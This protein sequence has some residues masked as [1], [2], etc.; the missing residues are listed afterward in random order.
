M[1]ACAIKSMFTC[2]IYQLP[3]LLPQK[4]DNALSY[5][6]IIAANL[7]VTQR[8]FVLSSFHTM[9]GRAIN[10]DSNDTCFIVAVKIYVVI[11]TF[12]Y[13]L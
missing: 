1:L 3:Q 7:M 9:G 5:T 4:H 6:R 12:G 10:S 2:F 8:R 11:Y 13:F